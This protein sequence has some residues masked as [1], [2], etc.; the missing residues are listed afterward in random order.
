MTILHRKVANNL[1]YSLIG[2]NILF[3]MKMPPAFSS[4]MHVS[5]E[6]IM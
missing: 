6:E 3:Y 5:F 4:R 1:L 2:F